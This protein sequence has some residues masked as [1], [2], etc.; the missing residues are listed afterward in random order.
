MTDKEINP[1]VWE[2]FRQQEENARLKLHK[3]FIY[4]N[5]CKSCGGDTVYDPVK[6]PG[7]SY[8]PNPKC[9][10]YQDIK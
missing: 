3:P 5:S 6:Y 7:G 10:A 1:V 2:L 9:P 4:K 8:C